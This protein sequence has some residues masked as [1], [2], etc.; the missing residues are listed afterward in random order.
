MHTPKPDKVG[1]QNAEPYW[2]V[3]CCAR[4]CWARQFAFKILLYESRSR[5]PA[6]IFDCRAACHWRSLLYK[7]FK[8]NVSFGF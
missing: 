1:N 4:P 2:V 3:P 8:V 6:T 7:V 5:L